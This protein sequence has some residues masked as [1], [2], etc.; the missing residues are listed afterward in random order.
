MTWNYRL[1]RHRTR[2]TTWYGLH[3]VY[4]NQRKRAYLWDSKANVIG[5]TVKEI[6]GSL[7]MMLRDATKSD[8]PILN[9]SQMPG[10][11]KG[12]R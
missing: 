8:V 3:E 1:V 5:D 10:E 11:G 2:G 12:K 4:Y 7:A 6:V 9:K